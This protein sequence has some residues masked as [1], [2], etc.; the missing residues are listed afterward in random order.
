MNEIKCCKWCGSEELEE[1]I[2]G[3]FK[4]IRCIKCKEVLT[5]G[6]GEKI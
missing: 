4:K 3:N 6:E 2:I 1:V 5:E